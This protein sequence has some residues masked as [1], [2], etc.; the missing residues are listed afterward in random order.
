MLWFPL[1]CLELVIINHWLLP[2]HLDW[3]PQVTNC[4]NVRNVQSCSAGRRAWSST[5]HTSTAG[6]KWVEGALR[7]LQGLC[8][9]AQWD[10]RCELGSSMWAGIPCEWQSTEGVLTSYLRMT[11]ESEKCFWACASPFPV[12]NCPQTSLPADKLELAGPAWDKWDLTWVMLLN[13]VVPF[14]F[15]CPVSFLPTYH[16]FN[17][18]TLPFDAAAIEILNTPV[19]APH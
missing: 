11:D 15:A 8:G 9:K 13:R 18:W 2:F 16:S 14:S 5:F 12:E 19:V 17:L 4:L 10:S 3:S 6:M 7:L 1:S